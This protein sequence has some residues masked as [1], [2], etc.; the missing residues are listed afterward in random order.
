MRSTFARYVATQNKGYMS[1]PPLPLGVVNEWVLI[2][3][4]EAEELSDITL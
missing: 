3:R 4:M 2:S 1:Q